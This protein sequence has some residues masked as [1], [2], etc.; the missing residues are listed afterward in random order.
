MTSL[1]YIEREAKHLKMGDLFC[2][3]AIM[4]DGLYPEPSRILDIKDDKSRYR[5]KKKNVQIILANGRDLALKPEMI[6]V[7]A[8]FDD[9]RTD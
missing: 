2:H 1:L 7:V 4:E 9:T 6:V 5:K 3:W 8:E